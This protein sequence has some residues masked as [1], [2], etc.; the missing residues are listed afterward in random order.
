MLEMEDLQVAP[1]VGQDADDRTEWVERRKGH[2]PAP[3]RETT[4][5]FCLPEDRVQVGRSEWNPP[6]SWQWEYHGPPMHQ[7]PGGATDPIVVTLLAGLA[8]EAV[9]PWAVIWLSDALVF[10]VP[11]W[12]LW[13]VFGVPAALTLLAVLIQWVLRVWPRQAVRAAIPTRQG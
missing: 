2:P 11:A 4:G 6:A 13:L 12:S 5:N 1:D 10:N 9:V 3:L 8:A 7:A